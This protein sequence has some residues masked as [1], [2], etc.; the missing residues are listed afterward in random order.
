MIYSAKRRLR[1][2]LCQ[3]E[4]V[5]MKSWNA[6]KAKDDLINS[7]HLMMLLN[8]AVLGE[9]KCQVRV[10]SREDAGSLQRRAAKQTC[11]VL[12]DPVQQS[13]HEPAVRPPI[14]TPSPT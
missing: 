6:Q 3:E 12:G 7:S 1:T 11:H 9:A 10:A 14:A 5:L 2:C 13:P 4:V 8:L